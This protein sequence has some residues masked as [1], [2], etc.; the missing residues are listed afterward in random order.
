MSSLTPDVLRSAMTAGGPS[1]LV[2]T[3]ELAPAG[4]SQACEIGGSSAIWPQT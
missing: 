4:G 1:V 2:S 3:T